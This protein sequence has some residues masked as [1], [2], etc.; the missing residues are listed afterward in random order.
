M[1]QKSQDKIGETTKL[2]K[3]SV[4]IE[5]KQRT[6]KIR[7]SESICES[8]NKEKKKKVKKKKKKNRKEKTETQVLKESQVIQRRKSLRKEN[9]SVMGRIANRATL[10]KTKSPEAIITDERREKSDRN[11]R[12]SRSHTRDERGRRN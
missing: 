3:E 2:F 5:D 6:L 12:S 1:K 7:I 4:E 9:K 10:V 8:N 11:K